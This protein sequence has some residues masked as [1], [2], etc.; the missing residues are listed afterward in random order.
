MSKRE[1]ALEAKEVQVK[2][3]SETEDTGSS[4]EMQPIQIDATNK[5]ND[6]KHSELQL[7]EEASKLNE[8]DQSEVGL[9][10]GRELMRCK[11]SYVA[12]KSTLL[13]FKKGD[14]IE[15]VDKSGK[16]HI[17]ILRNSADPQNSQIGKK[18]Y[19][20]PNYVEPLGRDTISHTK[21]AAERKHIKPRAR[22][23][24]SNPPLQIGPAKALKMARSAYVARNSNQLTFEK[25]DIIKVV[26]SSGRFM[27][28][29]LFKKTQCFA[30]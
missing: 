22:E 5:E 3:F 14:I 28:C 8:T 23:N 12:K 1:Q 10:P 11:F 20:P 2:I 15:R 13:S 18:L 27:H 17:G 30:F 4:L 25:G 6:A 9:L 26:K 19:Y 16:W 24:H 7:A 29:S 21:R